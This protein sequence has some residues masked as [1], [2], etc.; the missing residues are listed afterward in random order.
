ME[1]QDG[2]VLGSWLCTLWHVIVCIHGVWLI[3]TIHKVTPEHVRKHVQELTLMNKGI[4]SFRE[5]VIDRITDT[6]VGV[7]EMHRLIV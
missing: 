5:K 1:Q 2:V 6:T 4:S 3:N 7:K